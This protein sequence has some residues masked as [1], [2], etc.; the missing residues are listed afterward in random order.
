MW[1]QKIR[2]GLGGFPHCGLCGIMPESVF[3][4]D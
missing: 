1:W 4:I 3:G 2:A